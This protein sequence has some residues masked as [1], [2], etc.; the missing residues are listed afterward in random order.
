ML[1]PQSYNYVEWLNFYEANEDSLNY[2]V[3]YIGLY[4]YTIEWKYVYEWITEKKCMHFRLINTNRVAKIN[5]SNHEYSIGMVVCARVLFLCLVFF[6]EFFEFIV[7]QFR[8]EPNLYYFFWILLIFCWSVIHWTFSTINHENSQHIN[9]SV[10]VQIWKQKRILESTHTYMKCINKPIRSIPLNCEPLIFESSA[11]SSLTNVN[12][13]ECNDVCIE[14]RKQKNQIY[15]L[16]PTVKM[17]FIFCCVFRHCNL[18]LFYRF[19]SAFDG[20]A[21]LVN[22]PLCI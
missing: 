2:Q 22:K 10:C 19:L 12:R 9:K 4:A 11:H 6:Y 13:V 7:V 15:I 20:S 3:L 16:Q 18:Y 17:Y 14:Y 1:L 21:L 8:F 5:K